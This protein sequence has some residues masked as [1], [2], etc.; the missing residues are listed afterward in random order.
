MTGEALGTVPGGEAL[1]TVPG[2]E[3]LGTVP[4]Y[5]KTQIPNGAAFALAL[6]GAWSGRTK[7]GDK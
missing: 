1:G 3:A 2:G 5:N 6:M 4:E 7:Q